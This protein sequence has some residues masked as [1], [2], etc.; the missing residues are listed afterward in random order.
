[1]GFTVGGEDGDGDDLAVRRVVLEVHYDGADSLKGQTD[2]SGLRLWATS[3]WEKDAKQRVGLLSV[4]DP[5]ARL[6]QNLP[7][8]KQDVRYT[9]HCPPGCTSTFAK[10]MRVSSPA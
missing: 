7:K 8:N 3:D 9:T 2:A 4:A 1:V 10:P 5:F 6:P